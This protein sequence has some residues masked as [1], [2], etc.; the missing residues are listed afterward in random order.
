MIHV[1]WKWLLYG[2]IIEQFRETFVNDKKTRF[3][4]I[5]RANCFPV[6]F[7]V[8]KFNRDIPGIDTSCYRLTNSVF[9]Q[10]HTD[11]GGF[12]RTSSGSK[13]EFRGYFYPQNSLSA[14]T[15]SPTAKHVRCISALLKIFDQIILY[16]AIQMYRSITFAD[17]F[18]RNLVHSKS[19]NFHLV[20]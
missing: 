2:W 1:H 3:I 16:H 9:S 12:V 10:Q 4:W 15:G 14:L 5:S 7:D 13:I 11:I 18:T 8:R 6:I 19:L 20:H 17:K